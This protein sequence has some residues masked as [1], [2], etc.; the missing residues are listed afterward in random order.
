M[1]AETLYYCV[2]ILDCVVYNNDVSEVAMLLTLLC[3]WHF[4]HTELQVW[5]KL[6][7]ITEM[8]SVLSPE[9]SLGK[10]R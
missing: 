2:A 5:N 8:N 9:T 7:I 1:H 6:L 3:T 10:A 4:R